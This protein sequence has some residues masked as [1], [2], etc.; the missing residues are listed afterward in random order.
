MPTIS[1]PTTAPR[2][3]FETPQDDHREHF[4]AD[5]RQLVVYA[6]HGPPDDATER[7]DDPRHRPGECEIASYI[8]AHRHRHLLAVGNRAHCD[9][10]AALEEE[11][12]EGGEKDDADDRADQ[13]D[14]GSKTGPS[15]IGS[16][17]IGITIA[18]VPA[19]KARV[20]AAAQHRRKSDRRH[21][22]GN[23][24]TPDQ[25]TQHHPLEAEAEDDH[26]RNREQC[27]DPK[28]VRRRYRRRPR[29]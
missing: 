10:D 8:D 20:A 7:R 18:R 5:E 28:G 21:H 2:I 3:E 19:P 4:E 24:R 25:R 26:A 23:D 12:A 27:R 13:L 29:R 14:R 9:A 6:E 17:L 22:D 1:P 11:P 15:S 16:S